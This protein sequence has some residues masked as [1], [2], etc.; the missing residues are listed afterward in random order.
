MSNVNVGPAPRKRLGWILGI[1]GV[2]VT[3]CII[4]ISAGC[5]MLVKEI[6]GGGGSHSEKASAMMAAADRAPESDWKLLNRYDPKID[7]GC[8]SIDTPCLK[9]S[10]SWLVDHPVDSY[11]IG[12]RMG[13]N[14][15]ESGSS[16][17]GANCTSTVSGDGTGKTEIC[18]HDS[19]DSPGDYQVDVFMT[20]R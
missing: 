15:A 16:S 6:N 1:I 17:M 3:I 14:M 11:E 8:L 20:Q 7:N 18:I 19:K 13:L 10:A 2:S 4:L 12:S 5:S 9:L